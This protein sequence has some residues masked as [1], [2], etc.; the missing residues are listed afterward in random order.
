MEEVGVCFVV[1]FNGKI[2]GKY[3]SEGFD[4]CPEI[5]SDLGGIENASERVLSLYLM[6]KVIVS[7][8]TLALSLMMYC[9]YAFLM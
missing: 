8:K 1:E 3:V 9:F 2:C 5:A 4:K 7:T 6:E